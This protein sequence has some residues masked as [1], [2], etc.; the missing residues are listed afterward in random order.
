MS[1]W[2]DNLHKL[3]FWNLYLGIG[4]R[5][6]TNSGRTSR[7]ISWCLLA[8]LWTRRESFDVSSIHFA[9]GSF[10]RKARINWIGFMFFLNI[11]QIMLVWTIQVAFLYNTQKWNEN[12]MRSTTTLSQKGQLQ[13]TWSREKRKPMQNSSEL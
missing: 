9:T 6:S 3:Q 12:S 4:G 1:I 10:E 11:G 13:Q 8:N 2:T 7:Y 5:L